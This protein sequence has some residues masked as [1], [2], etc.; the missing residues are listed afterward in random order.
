[1]G[2]ESI[3]FTII[4][5][6]ICLLGLY[7]RTFVKSAVESSVKHQFDVRLQELRQEFAREAE[8]RERRDRFRLAAL[9]QRLAAHQKAYRLAR[10]MIGT[11]H[12]SREQKREIEN[13][14]NK[15]W[16][17]YCL[18]LSNE[19]RKSFRQVLNDFSSYYLYKAI[20]KTRQL[21]KIIKTYL[22]HGTASITYLAS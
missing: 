3:L 22:M 2:T 21:K 8:A 18:Y 16:D 11:L 14:C 9:E 1:M 10:V 17:D 12:D 6:V 7:I 4:L 19:S 20:A 13:E 5:F 15:F